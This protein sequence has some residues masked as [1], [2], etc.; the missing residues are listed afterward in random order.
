MSE[1]NEFYNKPIAHRWDENEKIDQ[2]ES[3]VVSDP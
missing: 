3:D 2:G 1:R